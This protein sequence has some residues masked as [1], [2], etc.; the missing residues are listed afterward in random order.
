[1][2][3]CARVAG[4]LGRG[5][6]EDV[7]QHQARADQHSRRY[8]RGQFVTFLIKKLF[9]QYLFTLTETLFYALSQWD[10]MSEI[11]VILAI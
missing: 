8:C 10:L 4:L 5:E 11:N 6:G 3:F 7:D 1:M 2:Y 9:F